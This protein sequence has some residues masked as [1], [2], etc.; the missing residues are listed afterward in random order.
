MIQG[1]ISSLKVTEDDIVGFWGRE[2]DSESNKDLFISLE[3][4]MSLELITNRG[5]EFEMKSGSGR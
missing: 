2:S 1:Q 3:A 5:E 4:A